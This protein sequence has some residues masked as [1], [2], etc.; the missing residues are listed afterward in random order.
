LDTDAGRSQDNIFYTSV[1]AVPVANI[2]ADSNDK[3]EDLLDLSDSKFTSASSDSDG[4]APFL[5]TTGS[6]NRD[7]ASIASSSDMDQD[8]LEL[9]AFVHAKEQNAPEVGSEDSFQDEYVSGPVSGA[10]L[11]PDAILLSPAKSQGVAE[12]AHD[13]DNF[14]LVLLAS[15]HD[16]NNEDMSESFDDVYDS[17]DSSQGK[18]EKPIAHS[19][20]TLSNSDPV[21]STSNFKEDD[22][23]ELEHAE[24]L[25][26]NEHQHESE[27]PLDYFV[28]DYTS[29]SS[30]VLDNDGLGAHPSNCDGL[31]TIALNC[32]SA[33]SVDADHLDLGLAGSVHASKD[34]QIDED[35]PVPDSQIVNEFSPETST[36]VSGNASDAFVN[37]VQLMVLLDVSVAASRYDDDDD[38]GDDDDLLS[39][40]AGQ[41]NQVS[42]VNKNDSDSA[43]CSN[44]ALD[45]STSDGAQN[46]TNGF[47]VAC[48]D[49]GEGGDDAILELALSLHANEHKDTNVVGQKQDIL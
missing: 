33:E 11:E 28:N 9:A 37:T 42:Y 49:N 4:G 2:A 43:A 5:A 7:G 26:E 41:A 16:A 20:T 44:Q 31:S 25:H 47:D 24:A 34:N 1:E 13:N 40:A 15:L 14:D 8:I 39:E 3:K 32:F 23:D 12:A 6:S 29:D 27:N 48:T 46:G 30:K 17:A 10:L 18:M 35:V 45:S 21:C 19:T 36:V 22:H 38:D